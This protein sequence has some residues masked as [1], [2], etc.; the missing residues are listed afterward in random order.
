M[1]FLHRTVYDFLSSTEIQTLINTQVPPIFQDPKFLIHI[2][3]ARCKILLTKTEFGNK[4][5]CYGTSEPPDTLNSDSEED[6]VFPGSG[7]LAEGFEV[8]MS[9]LLSA[10]EDA[11]GDHHPGC[12][13]TQDWDEIYRFLV[14]NGKFSAILKIAETHELQ[15]TAA[16]LI[17]I[18]QRFPRES[19][20]N[21]NDRDDQDRKVGSA[22]LTPAEILSSEAFIAKVQSPRW[23]RQQDSLTLVDLGALEH[24][25]S[26]ELEH[27]TSEELKLLEPISAED[28]ELW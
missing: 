17:G 18:A 21:G 7:E 1:T 4:Q 25:T 15:H 11:N 26:A 12:V 9:A 28:I 20:F 3:L 19:A 16:T 23:G 6:L 22:K 24:F 2:R 13:F 27:F 14:A 8:T 5:C 10:C